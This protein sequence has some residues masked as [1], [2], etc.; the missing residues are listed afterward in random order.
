V[1]WRDGLTLAGEV[2]ATA[3]N[4]APALPAAGRVRH[5]YG[6]GPFARL[7]M[8]PLP[9]EPG[10]YVWAIADVPLY[11]GQT[12]TPLRKRLGSMGY[13]TI[14]TYNTYARQP[15][16]R[17]GG[18]QTNCRINALANQILATGGAIEIWYRV[19]LAT[20]ARAAESEFMRRYGLPP[21]N[22]ST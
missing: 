22:R 7:V 6:A 1:N 9:A 12:T 19:T 5:V 13:S 8:P 14:S 16:Q 18:Q 20:A 17:N 3:I 4:V 2:R 21:W 11:V 10:I 15:G